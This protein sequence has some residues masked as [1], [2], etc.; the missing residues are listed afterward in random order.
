MYLT[1]PESCR[2]H[3]IYLQGNG[4]GTYGMYIDETGLKGTQIYDC[5]I[6]S[7]ITCGIYAATGASAYAIQGSIHRNIIGGT[8]VKGIDID[9]LTAYAFRIWQNFISGTSSASIETASTGIL[10]CDNWTDR[11]PSGTGTFRDNHYSS[12]GA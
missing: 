8:S 3:D 4:A 11:Q 7:F 10:T 6:D 5:V 2:L 9:I 12:A 1:P